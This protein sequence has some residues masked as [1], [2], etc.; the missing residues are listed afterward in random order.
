MR[1][2][3][4]ASAMRVANACATQ[5]TGRSAPRR[6]TAASPASPPLHGGARGTLRRT[7]E[8]RHSRI[9]TERCLRSYYP[10]R[11]RSPTRE[12]RRCLLRSLSL[13]A[14]RELRGISAGSRRSGGDEQA[15]AEAR[16]DGEGAIPPAVG[17]HRGRT[18]E[19]LSLTKTRWIARRAREHLDTE[20]RA[21]RAVEFALDR[22]GRAPRLR[23]V[24]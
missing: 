16:V 24:D 22:P 4:T 2:A 15:R 18:E 7:H 12:L 5:R 3:V 14:L 8:R 23:G 6:D 1:V 17:R 20:R 13:D 10:V 19:R 21:R 9:G 11:G